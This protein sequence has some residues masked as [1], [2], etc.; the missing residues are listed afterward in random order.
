M[1][2]LLFFLVL[3]W[4]GG[5]GI[6]PAQASAPDQDSQRR[7]YLA[8]L[9]A[10]K[11]GNSARFK[12][13]HERLNGYILRGYLEYEYLKNRIAETKS[14]DIHRFLEENN[15][16][17]VSDML[18]KRWLRY[19]AERGDWEQFLEEYRDVEG[20]PTL[21]C[22]RLGRLLKISEQQATLMSEVENLWLTGKR[23]PDSCDP[24]FAAWRKAGHMTA[25]KIW[26]RIRLAMESRQLELASEIATYLDPRERIWV[27]RWQAMHRDPERELRHIHYPVETPIARMIVK[28]GVVR[29]AYRDPEEAMQR[30]EKLKEKYQFFGEDDNYVLRYLGILAAQNYSPSALQ[31]LSAVVADAN[32]ESL[33]LWRVKSALRAGQWYTAR[34]FITALSEERSRENVWRYWNARILEATNQKDEAQSL[35]RSLAQ[36]RDYYGFLAA[37]RINAE[38]SMRHVSVDA[39]TEELS[40]MLARPGIQIAQ[41]LH[42]T[43]QTI[44]AR[45][46]WNWSTRRMNNRELQVAAVIAR[47]WG[48]HDRAIL[49][50][51][52]SE[53]QDDLDLRFPLLYRDMIETNA[54]E[55]GIDPSWVYGVVRQESAF[56]V[57]ARSQAGA[58]GLMQLMPATGRITGR[59]LKIPIRNNRALLDIGNNLRLGVSYLR[60]VLRINSGNQVLATASYNAGPNRVN[61]WLPVKQAMDADVWVENIPFSETREYVK[62]VMAYTT[63]YDFRLGSHPVRLATRMSMI[64]PAE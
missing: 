12:I 63:V 46:Q 5:E 18:R 1:S 51:A 43:G 48:W 14:A 53:R 6:P 8:A 44:D 27:K 54:T 60:E 61:N 37:D 31:W 52:K 33:H 22:L 28:H 38:Y 19:L 26:S 24:V 20:D 13:L 9:E 30:W 55:H 35:Y 59:R 32:D 29:L 64:A 17:P 57:D 34:R 49:T 56:V 47:Q 2:R 11:D 41:E 50:V 62:N 7:D 16:A 15:Q 40:A 23:L 21:S 4:L 42:A 3:V 36:D 10:V 39:S 58:L 25:E 45:R